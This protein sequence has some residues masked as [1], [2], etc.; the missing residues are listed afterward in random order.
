MKTDT[1]SIIIPVYNGEKYIKQC[2][3]TIKTQNYKNWEAIFINDGSKDNTL[4]LLEELSSNE[5][6]IKII[7][8]KNM[9]AAMARRNG[10]SVAKGEFITFLDVDDTL[11]ITFLNEMIN[12]INENNSDICV[13]PYNIIENGTSKTK[14]SKLLG[15]FGKKDFLKKVLSLKC[16]WELC[17]KIYRTNLFRNE[18]ITPDNIRI[19]EDASIFFQLVARANKITVTNKPLYN[20]IQYNSSASH[21]KSTDYAME[22]LKAACFIDS[23]FK[24]KEYYDDIKTY[25]DCMYLLFYSNSTRKAYIDNS[26]EFLNSILKEHLNLKALSKL[27]IVK[28]VYIYLSYLTRKIINKPLIK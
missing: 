9:G 24:G 21:V 5:E 4:K 18:I 25:I 12:A 19:G 16:G 23:I 17:S 3:D 11:E 6:R 10:I 13:C 7:D 28:S 14:R 27:E 26:N 1:I 15:T 8:Q 22:T 2:A 20:Y